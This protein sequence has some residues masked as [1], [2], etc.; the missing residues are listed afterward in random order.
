MVN[1]AP[2]IFLLTFVITFPVFAVVPSNLQL[3]SRGLDS[4]GAALAQ[5]LN[6]GEYSRIIVS[7]IEGRFGE[8][9]RNSLGAALTRAGKT[10]Y[11]AAAGDNSEKLLLQSAINDY[12]LRYVGVG[13]GI[14]RQGKVA[15]E[16]SV[17]AGGRLLA[18][19]GRLEH[20]LATQTLMIADTV[21][22]DQA[23]RARGDDSFL[24]PA[25]PPTTFQRLIE[26][27]VIAG[28]T[29]VLVY[30]FFASR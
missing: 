21:S 1:L 24:A 12:S 16:F 23:R 22:F 13:G 10:V 4:A 9:L 5:D 18:A 14:F 20:T 7:T 11:Y 25:L 8:Q 30:L 3:C 17:S 6:S 26:P 2:L 28:I 15:R 19:D 29:G 27:G